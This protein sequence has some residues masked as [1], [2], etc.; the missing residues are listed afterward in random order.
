LDTTTC[1]LTRKEQINLPKK[2][3]L[4]KILTQSFDEPKKSNIKRSGGKNISRHCCRGDKP[5]TNLEIKLNS[6]DVT[7]STRL[8]NGHT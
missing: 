6:N 5:G 4:N 1:W 2:Q 7:R 8:K 3:Q